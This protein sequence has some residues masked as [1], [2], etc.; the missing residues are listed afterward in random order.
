MEK[1]A[2]YKKLYP[3]D[4]DI[5]LIE[6]SYYFFNSQFNKAEEIFIKSLEAYPYDVDV[7]FMLSNT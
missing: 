4:T 2:D 6:G 7:Y 3:Y 1:T 5:F